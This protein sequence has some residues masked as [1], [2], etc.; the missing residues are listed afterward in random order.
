MSEIKVTQANLK[1]LM[2][3][4]YKFHSFSQKLEHMSP[5]V[6]SDFQELQNAVQALFKE[7]R[8]QDDKSHDEKSEL[9]DLVREQHKF[10]SIWSIYKMSDFKEQFGFVEAVEYQ[11]H[12]EVVG[13]EVTWLQLWEIADRLIEL[14]G[15]THH[16]FVENFSK[17]DKDIVHRLITGS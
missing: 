3:I 11:G 15:D 4:Q 1:N 12:T 2:D 16:L 7:Q 6:K 5:Q 17:K 13:T 14:S 10:S 9:F 8:E